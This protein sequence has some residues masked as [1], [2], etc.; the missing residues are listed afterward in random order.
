MSLEFDGIDV[1]DDVDVGD[2]GS[3]DDDVGIVDVVVA[4]VAFRL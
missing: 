4:N 2:V 3:V 1:T